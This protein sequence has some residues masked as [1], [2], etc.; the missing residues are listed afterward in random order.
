MIITRY[1][2]KD[3]L[4]TLGGVLL[5]LFL[6]AIS[7]Q[8]VGLFSDVAAG[9][10]KAGTVANLFGL[11]LL[12]LVPLIIPLALY[13]AVLLSLTRLYRDSEL[14][15][16]AACG[17]GPYQLMKAVFIVAFG[18]A[19]VQGGFTLFF[20]PWADAAGKQLESLSKKTVDIQGITP[21]RFRSLP[22]GRGVIYVESIDKEKHGLSNIF[23]SA[24]FSKQQT[25]V[26][27]ESG[28]IRI[29]ADTGDRFLELTNG[30]RYEGRPGKKDFSVVHFEK[31]GVRLESRSDVEVSYRH[32]SI[33]TRQLLESSDVD[34][35]TELQWR[36]SQ[37]LLCIVL[38]LLAVPLSR[39]SHRQGRYSR[40]AV[41]ILLY[42]VVTNLLNVARGSL[43]DK[44]IPLEVGLWWV[45]ALTLMLTLILVML[46]TG[47]RHYFQ[48]G[49]QA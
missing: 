35:L 24:K 14:A 30:F 11:Y 29:D 23:L 26:T 20:S 44:V 39:T 5:V 19:L 15:A 34:H 12:K 10:L 46:Q 25:L 43:I 27:A 3:L 16:L 47:F 4:T 45:H 13:L 48:R 41:A 36:I 49:K 28:H 31:H 21:G 8:L 6:M 37:A 38:A 32:R 18:V 40:I 22:Q 9:T 33:S 17:F 1:L 2:I 42:L 7:A